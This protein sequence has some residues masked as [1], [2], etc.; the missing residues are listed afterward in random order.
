MK[1]LR[2]RKK[3]YLMFSIFF[4][5]YCRKIENQEYVEGDFELKCDDP[6]YL[7][8]LPFLWIIFTVYVIL[9]PLSLTVLI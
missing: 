9:T 1:I 3:F 7:K 4:L 8:N 5:V 6:I 2:L